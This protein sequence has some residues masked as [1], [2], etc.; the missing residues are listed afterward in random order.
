MLGLEAAQSPLIGVGR[1]GTRAEHARLHSRLVCGTQLED[2]AGAFREQRSGLLAAALQAIAG[3]V[4]GGATARRVVEGAGDDRRDGRRGHQSG[5]VGRAL[6]PRGIAIVGRAERARHPQLFLGIVGNALK[7]DERA[8]SGV[9]RWDP[10]GVLRAGEIYIA[11]ERRET[12]LD[13]LKGT[14]PPHRSGDHHRTG[15]RRPHVHGGIGGKGAVRGDNISLKLRTVEGY[16]APVVRGE[17]YRQPRSVGQQR[18]REHHA[19]RGEPSIRAVGRIP[20]QRNIGGFEGAGIQHRGGAR[21]QMEHIA[22]II[23][24]VVGIGRVGVHVGGLAE[25]VARVGAVLARRIRAIGIG[26]HPGLRRPHHQH[27]VLVHRYVRLTVLLVIGVEGALHIQLAGTRRRPL[28]NDARLAL[29]MGGGGFRSYIVAVGVVYPIERRRVDISTELR[30]LHLNTRQVLRAPHALRHNVGAL[31]PRC[32]PRIVAASRGASRRHFV[33]LLQLASLDGQSRRRAVVVDGLDLHALYR[34]IGK[35]R[36]VQHQVLG[37]EAAS[38]RHS[39]IRDARNEERVGHRTV[40]LDGN[41]TVENLRGR[42]IPHVERVARKPL[43]V[44]DVFALLGPY[45]GAAVQGLG[46][47]RG[48]L[49]VADGID[50]VARIPRLDAGNAGR[51]GADR[52]EL[53]VLIGAE[54]AL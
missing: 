36:L 27:G 28:Q 14:R 6:V 20:C 52:L 30:H 7:L 41:D 23:A 10:T 22:R 48:V 25:R 47:A 40:L 35:Q 16:R 50:V 49:L 51:L 26:R 44:V 31:L 1:Q 53:R 45:L 19:V 37:L 21:D 39:P 3:Q 17:R 13:V 9:C 18:L 46:S 43:G 4:R 5:L 32:R 42:A 38:F 8:G 34:G 33:E 12:N 54:R 24:L 29:A 2:V 15:K 11:L